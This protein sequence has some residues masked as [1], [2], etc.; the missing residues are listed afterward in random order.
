M[1]IAT[2]KRHFDINCINVRRD[3][4]AGCGYPASDIH[5][6]VMI[7]IEG[8][9]TRNRESSECEENTGNVDYKSLSSSVC[10]SFL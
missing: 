8:C 5:A 10:M 1:G 7:A 4:I 9:E 3:E 2:A 6:S